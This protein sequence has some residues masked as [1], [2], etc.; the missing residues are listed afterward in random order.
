MAIAVVQRNVYTSERQ[1]P[2]VERCTAE[3][4][5]ATSSREGAQRKARSRAEG[6]GGLGFIE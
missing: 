4:T 2:E 6:D 1:A 3:V 5:S